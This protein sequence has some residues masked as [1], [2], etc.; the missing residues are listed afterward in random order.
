VTLVRPQA[1]AMLAALRS[2]DRWLFVELL[3]EAL[4]ELEAQS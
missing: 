3:E 4:V 2:A 1:A